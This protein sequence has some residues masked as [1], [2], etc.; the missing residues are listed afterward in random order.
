MMKRNQEYKFREPISNTHFYVELL[1][2][3]MLLLD[4]P[5]KVCHFLLQSGDLCVE[6][7]QISVVASSFLNG[8]GVI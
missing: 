7:L 2:A 3:V 1:E 8:R 6:L 5:A 4:H